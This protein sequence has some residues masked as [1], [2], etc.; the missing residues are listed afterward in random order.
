MHWSPASRPHAA[1][2]APRRQVGDEL[3]CVACVRGRAVAE[4]RFTRREAF[5]ET[6]THT[7]THT[8][9]HTHT[10]THTHTRQLPIP[11]AG[12][13]P[14]PLPPLTHPPS[15]QLPPA[16]A[17]RASLA[18]QDLLLVVVAFP[19]IRTVPRLVLFLLRVSKYY[20]R[21]REREVHVAPL[22]VPCV[23]AA[24]TPQGELNR[25][26]SVRLGYHAQ[27]YTLRYTYLLTYVGQQPAHAYG[28]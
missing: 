16:L 1:R 8:E 7:R 11:G 21:R 2:V 19:A 5:Q 27:G 13:P 6:H 22:S 24:S 23:R 17:R 20:F 10:H 25:S 15:H 12:F 9:T 14:P 28:F 3:G 26:K 18:N 4:R